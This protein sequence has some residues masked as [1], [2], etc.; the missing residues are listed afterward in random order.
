MEKLFDAL[1]SNTD[2]V[3]YELAKSVLDGRFTWLEAGIIDPSEGTGPWIATWQPGPSTEDN[4]GRR[5]LPSTKEEPPEEK[6]P[7]PAT[8]RKRAA[9]ARKNGA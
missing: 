3:D 5:Y 6:K 1:F 9:A 2:D 4:V 7:A 8:T